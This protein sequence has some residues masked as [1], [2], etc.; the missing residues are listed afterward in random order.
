[1]PDRTN[2]LECPA[3][4]SSPARGA[5]N[6]WSWRHEASALAI[7]LGTGIAALALMIGAAF[8]MGA[9]QIRLTPNPNA[10]LPLA[11]LPPEP[12]LDLEAFVH[13]RAIYAIV[14]ITCHGP[15]GRGMPGLGRDLTRST[16]VSENKDRAL[17]AFIRA[18]RP[19]DHPLNLTKV[20]MPP[21]AGRTDMTEENLAQVVVFL[22]GL[23][24]PRRVPASAANTPNPVVLAPPPPSDEDRAK[25]LAAAGGDAELAEFIAS[26]SRLFVTSCASCHGRDAKGMPGLG[27]D[28]TTSTFVAERD[29]DQMLAF[30]LKGRDTSDPLNITKVAMPPKGGNPALNEDDLLDIIAFLR[31]VH[32]PTQGAAR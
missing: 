23:Q 5:A 13:G 30:L 12:E 32:G 27:R 19:A 24:D 3:Q 1:M 28:L 26:G 6:L 7:A 14:C 18:G 11:A 20:A 25:A 8:M 9:L 17:A 4:A 2:H 29:D 16:F 22:R 10:P 21:M 31:S 15:N